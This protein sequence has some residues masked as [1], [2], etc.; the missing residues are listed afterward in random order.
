MSLAVKGGASGERNTLIETIHPCPGSRK[1]C[2]FSTRGG[3]RRVQSLREGRGGRV[4]PEHSEARARR[5][6]GDVVNDFLQTGYQKLSHSKCAC[7]ILEAEGR[8][9]TQT[10]ETAAGSLL[11]HCRP[12][13]P[14]TTHGK[15]PFNDKQLQIAERKT[16]D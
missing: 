6:D 16:G 15:H 7:K 4:S 2:P 9:T 14:Y 12:A 13:H 8:N 1:A 10:E 3:T 11:T 5:Q